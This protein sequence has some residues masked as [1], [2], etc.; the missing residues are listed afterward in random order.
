MNLWKNDFNCQRHVTTSNIELEDTDERVVYM[1]DLEKRKQVYGIC[2]E[3]KE[4]GTG[5]RWCQ[6]CNAKR[7]KD[8]FK[9]WTSGNKDI[10]EFIQQSQLNAVHHSKCLEWIPFEKFQNINYVTEGGFGKI[11]SAERP[12]GY[13]EYWNIEKQ[14]WHRNEYNNKYALK[15]LRNSFDISSDFLNEL[16]EIAKGLSDIHNA[17]K[18]HKNLH[19]GNILYNS[20]LPYISELG[21]YQPNKEGCYGVL[22][23][24][25]PEILYGR[26]YTK[27]ANIY[28]FGVMMNEIFS[29]EIPY[30]DIPYDKLLA[31]KVCKGLRPKISED[32][33]KFFANLIIKCWD[34][35]IENRPTIKELYQALKKSDNEKSDNNIVLYSQIGES[36]RKSKNKLNE[37]KSKNV[38]IH[39][40]AIYTSKHLNFK[41]LPEP[42]NSI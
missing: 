31:V 34:A 42:V 30:N 14:M 40:E 2:G 13:I 32:I 28:S 15:S 21:M 18:V 12:E 39:P 37:G 1:E 16:Q 25:A 10:D 19:P 4:P 3:C 20:T 5:F 38:Q 17:G 26:P 29:E 36:D 8:N 7:F 22:P 41:D 6:S 27:A 33:P 23:Y 9:N 24:I 11:Y 35:V